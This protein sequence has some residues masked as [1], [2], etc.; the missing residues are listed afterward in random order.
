MFVDPPIID[1]LEPLIIQLLIPPIILLKAESEQPL[2][3]VI[4]KHCPAPIKVQ[5]ADMQELIPPPIKT[6]FEL[7]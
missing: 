4:T 1:D 6:Q 5:S 2:D 3:E 7:F